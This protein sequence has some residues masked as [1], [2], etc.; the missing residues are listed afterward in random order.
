M[1]ELTHH[2]KVRAKGTKRWAFVSPRGTNYLRIHASMMT[3]AK[4]DAAL[5]ELARDN[6][7]LEFKKQLIRGV[8][9][10]EPNPRL[11]IAPTVDFIVGVVSENCNSFGLRKM[12]AFARNGAVISMLANDLYVKQVG[13]KITVRQRIVPHADGAGRVE[14]D[15]S[16]LHYECIEEMPDAP[17]ELVQQFWK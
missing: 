11:L 1:N 10:P 16:G 17:D 13:D 14:L 3:E 6:P 4:A 8:T 9:K 5:I 7:D 2:I 12:I 15:F